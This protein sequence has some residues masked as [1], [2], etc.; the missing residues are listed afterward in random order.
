MQRRRSNLNGSFFF[1]CFSQFHAKLQ[2]VLSLSL[3]LS[4]SQLMNDYI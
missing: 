2:P 3:S 4:P 1:L